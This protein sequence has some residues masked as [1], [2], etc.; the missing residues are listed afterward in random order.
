MPTW[1]II[2]LGWANS[3]R[4]NCESISSGPYRLTRNPQCVGNIVFHVGVST[5]AN[6]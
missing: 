1:G 3:S 4:L 5:A 2:A 6:S